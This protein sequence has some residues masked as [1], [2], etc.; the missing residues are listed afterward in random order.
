LFSLLSEEG[1]DWVWRRHLIEVFHLRRC[2]REDRATLLLAVNRERN[3]RQ[4]AQAATRNPHL[5]RRKTILQ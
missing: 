5:G 4:W 2:Y 1:E 3:K